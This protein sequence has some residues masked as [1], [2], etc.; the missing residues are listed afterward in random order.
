MEQFN[1]REFYEHQVEWYK[2]DIEWNTKQIEYYTDQLQR[3]RKED[4]EFIE[5]V[6]QNLNYTDREK[7]EINKYISNETKQNLA[8][9][10]HYYLSRK[11]GRANLAKYEKLL[12]D[13]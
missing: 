7:L 4:R 5:W 8:H 1:Y 6:Q 11:R 2:R 3:S 12:A 9:R 10:K 13:C